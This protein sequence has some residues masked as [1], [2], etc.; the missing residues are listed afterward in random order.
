MSLP[1]KRVHPDRAAIWPAFIVLC[2]L[3]L[4]PVGQTCEV[5]FVLG[6]LCGL[7]LLWRERSAICSMPGLR[8]AALLFACY[9]LPALISATDSIAAGK[10]WVSVGEFLRFLPFAAFA[11][12]ALRDARR[13]PAVVTAIAAIVLLWLLDAWVQIFSGYSLTGAAQMERL[14][15]IF[16]AG[17]P[18]LGLVLAVLAPFF[19]GTARTRFGLRGLC[20]AYFG[21]LVPILLAGERAA[22]LMF[23]V[24]TLVFAWRETRSVSKLLLWCIPLACGVA[25]VVAVA[26]HASPAFDARMQRTLLVLEGSSTAIDAASAG[27][28]RIWTTARRMIAA[29]PVNGVGVRAFRYAY[30]QYAKPGDA[31][32]DSAGEEG[33]LHAHQIFL[34]ILSETGS[35]GLLLWCLG[36]AAAIRAWLRANAIARARAAAPALALVVMMFPLNTHLAFYSAWWGLLLWWLIALFCAALYAVEDS[37]R[38]RRSEVTTARAAA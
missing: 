20:I 29:H 13:W 6:A 23:G 4:L 26:L 38:I 21:I 37:P 30:P 12:I 11:V 14:T 35:I 17:K 10:S 24:V 32:V 2:V 8:L 19:L 36:A 34:E 16:G 15:G 3:V 9:W 31:F 28:V 25:V 33:A 1:P 18:K 5:P 27:R 22:W 7:V